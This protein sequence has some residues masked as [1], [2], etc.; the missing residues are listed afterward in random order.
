VA[1]DINTQSAQY[2]QYMTGLANLR[3]D[4]LPRLRAFKRLGPEKQRWWLQRDPLLRRL[5]KLGLIVSKHVPNIMDREVEN[6]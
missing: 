6:D 1:I 4:M 2:Q 5:I 3:T